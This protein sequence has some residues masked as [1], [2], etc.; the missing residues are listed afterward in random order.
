MKHL[1]SPSTFITIDDAFVRPLAFI[2][3][4]TAVAPVPHANVLYS[5]SYVQGNA[6][7]FSSICLTKLI[8]LPS[9]P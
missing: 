3:I 8:L 7:V 2:A 5:S 6:K 1:A 4:A 9:S